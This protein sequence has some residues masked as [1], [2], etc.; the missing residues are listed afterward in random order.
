MSASKANKQRQRAAEIDQEIGR[1]LAHPPGSVRDR[2]IRRLEAEY[3]GLRFK[4][5]QQGAP[6]H[7]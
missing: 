6:D 1:L 5:L 3:A 2:L 4:P 7:G